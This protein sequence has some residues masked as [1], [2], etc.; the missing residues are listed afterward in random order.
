MRKFINTNTDFVVVADSDRIAT[1]GIVGVD[2]V[3]SLCT[4]YLRASAP[5]A[6]AAAKPAGKHPGGGLGGEHRL[7][8]R[9]RRVE[10]R[11]AE[12]GECQGQT[13][14]LQPVQLRC[15]PT[16]PMA[17]RCSMP[18][19]RCMSERRIPSA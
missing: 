1:A 9:L 6:K 10:V 4:R 18:D 8:G 11:R 3:R 5:A 19:S 7:G 2:A 12:L 13:W 14:Q 16:T 15:L 17:S